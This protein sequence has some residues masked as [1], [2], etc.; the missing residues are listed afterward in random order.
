MNYEKSTHTCRKFRINT[1]ITD[2]YE[3]ID[4]KKKYLTA[5]CS[6]MDSHNSKY[7]CDGMEEDD[8]PCPY[9]FMENL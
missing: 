5:N 8:I 1:I 9:V 6:L 7:K 2:G 4:G 3:I